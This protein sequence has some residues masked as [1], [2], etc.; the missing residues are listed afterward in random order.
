MSSYDPAWTA[1]SQPPY[2][3]RCPGPT[4]LCS[5]TPKLFLCHWTSFAELSQDPRVVRG[6]GCLVLWSSIL[7]VSLPLKEI[8]FPFLFKDVGKQLT[9]CHAHYRG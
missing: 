9:G 3:A 6:S 2:P 5:Q 7:W 4:G 1:Q 8:S